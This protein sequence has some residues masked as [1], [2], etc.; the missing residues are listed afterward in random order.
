MT[1]SRGELLHLARIAEHDEA[2]P[3][4]ELVREGAE[5]LQRLL[6]EVELEELYAK[7]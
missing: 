4:P 1:L 7:D 6:E 5:E 2:L 3:A